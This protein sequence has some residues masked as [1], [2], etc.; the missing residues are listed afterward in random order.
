[1][2]HGVLSHSSILHVGLI[3]I[4]G[5]LSNR[6][7]LYLISETIGDIHTVRAKN[8]RFSL[9]WSQCTS[10]RRVYA[11]AVFC[12][13]KTNRK[14]I[15]QISFPPQSAHPTQCLRTATGLDQADAAQ[16]TTTQLTECHRKHW[17]SGRRGHQRLLFRAS[18]AINLP[19]LWHANATKSD[20]E[21][22]WQ[23]KMQ[24]Y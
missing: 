4:S 6:A 13:S 15:N 5:F 22:M 16:C 11:R 8:E 3:F 18:D 10:P 9:C 12:L 7:S 14:L 19:P 17:L 24:N 20:T 1:M 2:E 21:I 23:I